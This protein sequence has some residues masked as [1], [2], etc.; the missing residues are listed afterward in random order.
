[1]SSQV[2]LKLLKLLKQW[3]SVQMEARKSD[4]VTEIIS[5]SSN[6]QYF[7]NY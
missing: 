1:M 4:L 2:K 5:V 3:L 7:F 6:K